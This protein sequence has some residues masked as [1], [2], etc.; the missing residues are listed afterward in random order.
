MNKQKLFADIGQTLANSNK[1]IQNT[2]HIIRCGKKI[3]VLS[4]LIDKQ[5]NPIA[6]QSLQRQLNST[7]QT[8]SNVYTGGKRSKTIKNKRRNAKKT[9][10]N[11]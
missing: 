2:E 4:S 7:K 8:C 3:N 9:R 10:R 1:T 11:H 6:K 5:T